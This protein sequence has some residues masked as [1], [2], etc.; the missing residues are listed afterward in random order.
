MTRTR[1]T[2]VTWLIPIK[3]GMPYLP[4]MLASIAC[5]THRDYQVI[6]W[7]NGSADGTVD[8]LRQWIP[9]RLPGEVVTDHPLPFGSSLAAMVE[10]AKTELCA[11]IDADDINEPQRLA[12]QV[13]FLAKHPDVAV[14]GSAMRH[15]GSDDHLLPDRSAP[16]LQDAEIRWRLRFC[17]ALNH[18]TV[19][20]RRSAVLAAGNYRDALPAEDYELWLRMA[21]N[22]RMANLAEPLVRYRVHDTSLCAVHQDRIDSIRQHIRRRHAASLL[23]G[24]GDEPR[25]R[26]YERLD[27]F[28]R[29]DVT[30]GDCLA[31]R[32][33]AGRAAQ[34]AGEPADY[35]RATDL[36][37][38]QLRSLVFRRVK[39][40]A[41]VGDAY[42]WLS[43]QRRATPQA[44]RTGRS[45]RRRRAA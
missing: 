7:D 45:V 10:Q 28:E 20:F 16:P 26:L 22:H 43:R 29:L 31:L 13:Q 15:M 38:T 33:S 41:G 4:R 11:R 12:R 14:L 39:S 30:L 17:N 27:D 36:Y 32:R 35:F 25:R 23:P 1:S 21:L 18:P 42:T 9:R 2:A 44:D 8:V 5:Q 40:Q 34:A 3:N 19:V 37:Q 24:L 6:A